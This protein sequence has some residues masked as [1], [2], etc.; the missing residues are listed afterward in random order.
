MSK[1]VKYGMWEHEN[2]EIALENIRIDSVG[3]NAASHAYPLRKLPE[4][5]L[6]LKTLFCSGKHS[7]YCRRGSG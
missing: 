7:S 2:V 1:V 5:T 3:V 6:G 4:E